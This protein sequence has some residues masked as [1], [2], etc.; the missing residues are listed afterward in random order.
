MKK[1]S[2]I[3]FLFLFSTPSFIKANPN[4]QKTTSDWLEHQRTNIYLLTNSEPFKLA[5]KYY[6][7]WPSK[8]Y[9]PDLNGD[10]LLVYHI[11]DIRSYGANALSGGPVNNDELHKLVDIEEA[12]GSND[13]DNQINRG[14]SGDPF[15]GQSDN[16]TF[17]Q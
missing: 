17:N 11:D 3:L 7:F 12:D 1:L 5:R 4:I 8:W 6:S 15:P 14:D 2:L 9:Q 16:R 10:G 13:L